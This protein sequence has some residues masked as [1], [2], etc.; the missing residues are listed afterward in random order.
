MN[1]RGEEEQKMKVR[2]RE[3]HLFWDQRKTS[4]WVTRGKKTTDCHNDNWVV[5]SIRQMDLRQQTTGMTEI[6]GGGQVEV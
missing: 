2:Q 5:V 3:R 4:T 1:N 6:K